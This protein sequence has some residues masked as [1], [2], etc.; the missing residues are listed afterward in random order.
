MCR[1][2]R[3]YGKYSVW[4]EASGHRVGTH[5]KNTYAQFPAQRLQRSV[6]LQ[7]RLS[8]V[9]RSKLVKS[10]YRLMN[11]V[12]EQR[13]LLGW[14][15]L[16]TDLLPM[17]YVLAIKG[18]TNRQRNLYIIYLARKKSSNISLLCIASASATN[19][20]TIS[21]FCFIVGTPVADCYILLKSYLCINN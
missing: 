3:Y 16:S 13:R 11:V 14:P 17:S 8:L 6:T 15:N 9:Q 19:Y 1:V 7:P 10:L 21:M 12:R 4:R 5:E 18:M 20:W 2:V